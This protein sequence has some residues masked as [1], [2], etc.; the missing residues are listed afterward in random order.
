MVSACAGVAERYVRDP[1]NRLLVQ[2]LG[3]SRELIEKL[4]SWRVAVDYWHSQFAHFSK[5]LHQ[6]RWRDMARLMEAEVEIRPT[7]PTS[8]TVAAKL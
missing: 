6:Y 5:E 4:R 8:A 1:W 2:D 7:R 3:D